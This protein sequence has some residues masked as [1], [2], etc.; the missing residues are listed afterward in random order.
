MAASTSPGADGVLRATRRRRAGVL[1]HPT[2]LPGPYGIGDIG[3]AARKFLVWLEAAQQQ[4]WQMLPVNPT[5]GGGSPYAS[6]SAF[7]ASPLLL[8]IDDLVTDGWLTHGD[9]PFGLGSTDQ[10]HFPEVH[11][12][13]GAVLRKAADRVR[14]EVDLG[15]WAAGHAWADTWGLF[16]ALSRQ[17]GPQWTLWPAAL[18]D[19]DPDALGLARDELDDEVH[20]QLALQWMFEHQWGRLRADAES[21]G[22]SL[23]GDMPFFVGGESADVWA[24][25]ELFRLDDV[26]R[27]TFGSGAPPDAFTPEGQSWGTPL[28]DEA[29]H[30]ATRHAWWVARIARTLELFHEVRLDHFRGLAAYWE[31]PIGGTAVDGRWI[32]GPGAPML[33]A[34]R[35]Q[36]GGLPL[37]AEDLG[38]ITPDVEALRTEFGLPGMA[39]LQFAFSDAET[40]ADHPYMPHNHRHNTVVYPG[41]HDNDTIHGWYWSSDE[42]TRDHVRRYLS[43]D[44]SDISGDLIRA[45]FRSVADTAIVQLQDL[46]HLTGDARMN[47]PGQADGN[48]SWRAGPEATS[49]YM[50]RALAEEAVITGRVRRPLGSATPSA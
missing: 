12:V 6:P 35:E 37:I 34:A 43:C 23:W 49:L 22:I 11:R 30:A 41:T 29:A 38:I 36:L 50:A 19:R 40:A 14:K 24:H 27:P 5:D 3:P 15:A 16:A 18:R 33:H 1:L 26:G 10:V 17:H 8:S 32:P 25:R 2:S 4:V 46:L 44:G 9:K 7:S 31:I 45:A 47:V 13:K 20:V 42:K 28:Y 39:I 21:R 48:W